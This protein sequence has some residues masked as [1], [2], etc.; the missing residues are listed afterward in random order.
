[1]ANRLPGAARRGDAIRCRRVVRE[2]AMS[3]DAATH[4]RLRGVAW[5][6]YVL[7]RPGPAT[8]AGFDYSFEGLRVHVCGRKTFTKP[9]AMV[10]FESGSSRTVYANCST[11]Y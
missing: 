4:L 6:G 1:M 7:F 9:S 11:P 2:A 10:S 3:G 5:T 8:F